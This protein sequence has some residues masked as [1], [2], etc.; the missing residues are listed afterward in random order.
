MRRPHFIADQARNARGLLGHL[1]A[2][3]MARE[4]WQENRRAF[5]SLEIEATD[6]ILDIGCGHGRSLAALAALAPQGRVMGADPSVLMTAIALRRNRKLVNEGKVEVVTARADA[7]PFA[8]ASFDKAM[9]VNVVYFWPDL[10]AALFETARV[11]KPGGRIALV[12]R[13]DADPAT[14]AFPT[15]VYRFRPLRQMIAELQ[16][17]GFVVDSPSEILNAENAEPALLTAVKLESAEG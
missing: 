3:I 11:L 8:A 13:T 9:C 1:I 14:R 10:S 7:L 5:K 2:F 4:T 6:W 15:D 17:A 12:F 16:A